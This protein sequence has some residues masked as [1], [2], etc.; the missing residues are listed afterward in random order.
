MQKGWQ[1]CLQFAIFKSCTQHRESTE[2][3]SLAVLLPL[4]DERF[5][6]CLLQK[7]DRGVENLYFIYSNE[8][9]VC[10]PICETRSPTGPEG[11]KA[12]M[13]REIYVKTCNQMDGATK[14]LATLTNKD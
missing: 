8:G 2:S 6:Y 13:G 7:L 10:V 9:L 1:E 5:I 4:L 12:L 14:N 11:G 3:T